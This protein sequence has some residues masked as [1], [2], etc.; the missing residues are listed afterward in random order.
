MDNTRTIQVSM[1]A[2]RQAFI[3]YHCSLLQV[4]ERYLRCLL[5]APT[6][7]HSMVVRGARLF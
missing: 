7:E 1:L 2:V 6:P 5:R 3:Q 4:F